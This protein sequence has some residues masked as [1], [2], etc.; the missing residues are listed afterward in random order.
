MLRLRRSSA[1]LHSGSAQHDIKSLGAMDHAASLR[2]ISCYLGGLNEMLRP[3]V[4]ITSFFLVPIGGFV[5]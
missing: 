4:K 5:T 3:V 1:S 2:P